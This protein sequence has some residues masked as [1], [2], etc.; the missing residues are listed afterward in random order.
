MNYLQYLII[1]PILL[2]AA[3]NF[4]YYELINKVVKL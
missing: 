2:G 4:Y 3:I 1:L